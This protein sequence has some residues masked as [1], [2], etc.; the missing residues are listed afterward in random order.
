[1]TV[2]GNDPTSTD[3]REHVAGQLRRRHLGAARCEPLS[4]GRRD[5]HQPR[6]DEEPLSVGTLDAWARALAHLQ[7]VGLG[8]LPPAPVRK[9]LAAFPERYASVLP[10]RPAA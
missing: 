5:P 1:M 4:D 7:S 3:P 2:P 9:A 10:R 6:R 8:G